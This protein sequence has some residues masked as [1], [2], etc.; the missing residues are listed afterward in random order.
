[1]YYV[2]PQYVEIKIVKKFK[3]ILK[4]KIVNVDVIYNVIFPLLVF[5]II[6][7]K[8]GMSLF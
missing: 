2:Y 5:S 8:M 7:V 4:F 6:T 1:M 3:L